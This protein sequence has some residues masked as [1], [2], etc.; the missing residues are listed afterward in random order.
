MS[1]PTISAPRLMARLRRMGGIGA[2]PGGGV[3]RLALTDADREGRDQ[4]VAWLKALDM[5]VQIDAIGNIWG[6][7]P[8]WKT[9]HLS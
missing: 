8:A 2:L 5:S 7:A 9:V 1:R 4:F 6:G 3:S